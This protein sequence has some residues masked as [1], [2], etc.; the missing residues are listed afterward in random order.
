M[1]KETPKSKIEK[2][3]DSSLRWIFVSFFGMIGMSLYILPYFIEPKQSF[4]DYLLNSFEKRFAGAAPISL[5]SPVLFLV[6]AIYFVWSTVTYLKLRKRRKKLEE[7][8]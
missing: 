6:F 7:A 8:E 1:S 5:L 3:L 2:E 4:I